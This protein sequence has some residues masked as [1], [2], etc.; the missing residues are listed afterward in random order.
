MKSF[1]ILEGLIQY[2]QF[3][4]VN[5]LCPTLCNPMDWSMSGFPVNHQLPELA[6]THVNWVGDA[7]QP[8]YSLLSPS[9]P[10]FNLSQHQGLFQWVSSSHQV[11]KLLEIQL[12]HQS[13]QWIFRT[14]FLKDRWVWSFW[15]SRDSQKSSPTPQFKNINFSTISFLYRQHSTS[16]HDY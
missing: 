14:D 16:I 9:P 4:S 10:D 7:I 8:S 6:Q 12:Q 3:S 1:Q 15:D 5:H 11:T 13:L 2:H